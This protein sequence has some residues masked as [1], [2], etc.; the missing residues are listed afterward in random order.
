M[1]KKYGSIV[2]EVIDVL[3]QQGPMTRAELSQALN[4]HTTKI[5]AVLHRM[6]KD[7]PAKTKRV[8]I[9]GWVEEAEGQ[10]RYP[11]AIYALGNKPDVGKPKSNKLAIRRRYEEGLRKR[12]TMNSVFNMGKPRR[13]WLAELQEAKS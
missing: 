5:S 7:S 10:R 9:S 12:M 13:V 4:K 8:Y 2:N 3:F 11:R 6:R 1:T